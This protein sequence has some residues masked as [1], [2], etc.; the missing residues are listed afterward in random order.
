M[1]C[2]GGL[3]TAPTETRRSYAGPSL[4][5]SLH[6]SMSSPASKKKKRKSMTQF[7]PESFAVLVKVTEKSP[8]II[9]S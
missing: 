6:P 3:S 7:H 5:K 9:Q 4:L 2:K 8:K 1:G